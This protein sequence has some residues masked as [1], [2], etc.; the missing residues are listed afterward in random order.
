MVL[1]ESLA[2]RGLEKRYGTKNKAAQQRMARELQI[3]DQLDFN[4]YFL[5]TWDFVRF[6]QS[7]DFFHIG[8][9]S[10]ANSLI[11]YCLGITDVNPLELDLYF[12]RFLNPKRTSPPDFDIDYSWK[13]RD[14]V[15]DYVF[16]RYGQRHTA[17]LATYQ[18][19]KAR[20]VTREL[21]KVFGI[22]KAEIDQLLS[23]PEIKASEVD[24]VTRQAVRYAHYIKG[25]PS[26]LSVHAGGILI[27][28]QPIHSY[29]ATDMPPKG[30]PI[31]HFDMYEAE[32]IG[33]HKFDI[34]SQ[35]GLGHIKEATNL[36]YQNHHINIDV[37]D[38]ERF[39]KDEKVRRLLSTGRTVGCFY[40]ESPAMRQLLQKLGCADYLTLVAASSVIRPGVARSGMMRAYIERHHG[41]PF[42]YLHQDLAE[43]LAET[44]GVMVY[45]EDV[46]KVAHY[47]GGVDLA[48][49]DMLRRAMSR[50]A[51]YS[52]RI[53]SGGRKLFSRLSR[54]RLSRGYHQGSLATDGE[55]CRLLL[56]QGAFSELCR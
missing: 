29:T 51:A 5:I 2:Q 23:Q 16:K 45:Q 42:Q 18:H 55:L 53:S 37:H 13:D 4:A 48:E 15:I 25:F 24:E 54:K 41:H 38:I 33:L 7:C 9:G 20:S 28:N 40:I 44:Y 22:P 6:S 14:Q 21:G 50:E 19:F 11:A 52:H 34:L 49:A 32:A 27:A 56:L 36:V 47:F 1:L 26:H 8:R 10:G 31:T 17:M 12:E 3:I 30:F 39:K 35:R 43:I 46:I